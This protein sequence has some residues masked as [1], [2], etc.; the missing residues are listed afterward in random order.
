[1]MPPRAAIALTATGALPFVAA[2]LTTTGLWPIAG[3]GRAL[4]LA[5]GTVI[6]AFMAGVLW[7]FAAKGRA[8]WPYALSV[9][10]ALHV[11]FTVPQHPWRV[12][13]DPLAHLIANFAMLL[14]LDLLFQVKGL[15]PRWW[16]WLRVPVTGVVL[17]C[18]ILVR[19]G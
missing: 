12:A 9:L 4:A 15:A 8:L 1:M 3:D 5:Y 6:A 14:A 11:F 16:L 13:G 17:T 2:A 18:L 7:G 19:G 10:P